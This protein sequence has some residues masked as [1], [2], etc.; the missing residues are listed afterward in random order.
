MKKPP[1]VIY[2]QWN[3]PDEDWGVLWCPDRIND[4]DVEY[5]KKDEAEK[6]FKACLHALRSYMY[7]N[8]SPELAE[9]VENRVMEF[10][11]GSSGSKE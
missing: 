7:G 2:L 3:N 8:S 11:Y 1:K 5:I 10:L 4:D 6:V 9:E